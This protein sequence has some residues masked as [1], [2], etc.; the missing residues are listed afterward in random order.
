MINRFI[1]AKTRAEA[2]RRAVDL[3]WNYGREG[4]AWENGPKIKWLSV[5][6]EIED[7]LSEEGLA[8]ICEQVPAYSKSIFEEYKGM[9]VDRNC[10][11][12]RGNFK[13]SYWERTREHI[14][15]G[16]CLECQEDFMCSRNCRASET[17]LVPFDQ[18]GNLKITPYSRRKTIITGY[19]F[20][21]QRIK[22][23]PCLQFIQFYL[24][25]PKHLNM[26]VLFRSRDLFKAFLTNTVG[27][28]ELF[29]LKAGEINA[30]VGVYTDIS[31]NLH[32]YEEDWAIVEDLLEQR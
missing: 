29:K 25:G 9:L 17:R 30:K 3:V 26:T 31:T 5:V 21:D 19:P 16:I 28:V 12:V 32:I 23:P 27:L 14:V 8:E 15:P 22:E 20:K 4:L 2:W 13:Y 6:I 10:S 1:Y 7:V 18:I 24:D 11:V